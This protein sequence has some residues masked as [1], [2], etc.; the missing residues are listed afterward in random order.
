MNLTRL[1]T[2]TL[3]FAITLNLYNQSK[4]QAFEPP[5]EGSPKQTVSGSTREY[6]PPDGIGAPIVSDGS[7][8]R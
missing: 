6:Q 3:C 5:K 4:A 8:S 1:I 2:T 7:G